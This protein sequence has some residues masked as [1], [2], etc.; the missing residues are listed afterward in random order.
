MRTVCLGTSGKRRCGVLLVISEEKLTLCIR[1]VLYTPTVCPRISSALY[2]GLS[3]RAVG[4][5]SN[6]LVAMTQRYV[7]RDIL[8]DFFHLM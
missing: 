1:R 3:S 5:A 8:T 4:R 6:L 7:G 2:L